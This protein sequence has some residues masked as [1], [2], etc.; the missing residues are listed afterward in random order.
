M[1]KIIVILALFLLPAV[2]S[3]QQQPKS[4]E[5]RQKEFYEAIEKQIERLTTMLSL[6]DWQVF[7]VDSILTHDYKAMQEE[8]MD[9]SKAKVS[10]S[11]IYYDVQDR[12]MEQIYQSFQK[13]LSE[14]QWAKYQKS[15]AARD[16]KARDKRAAKKNKQ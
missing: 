8:V 5:E 10:N 4:E 11:D 7:Y 15:G 13:I 6:E 12:W 14:D 16:K 9:L 3:A 1:K 2:A